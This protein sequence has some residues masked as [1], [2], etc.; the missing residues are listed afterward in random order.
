MGFVAASITKS[1]DETD[2]FERTGKASLCSKCRFSVEAVFMSSGND[3][4]G[5]LGL[6]AIWPKW[7]LSCWIDVRLFFGESVKVV[8]IVCR[9]ALL[10]C[11]C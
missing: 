11:V 4:R 6:P 9:P 5:Y 1:F 10:G 2:W 8:S 3:G 7:Q